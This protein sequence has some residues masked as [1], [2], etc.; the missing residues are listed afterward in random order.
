M[1]QGRVVVVIDVLR[2]STTIATAL[3]QWRQGRH[4][5]RELGRGRSPARRHSSARDVSL[6]GERKMLPIPGFDLGNSPRSSRAEAVEG[7]TIL[8]DDDERH[9]R[10]SRRCRARVTWLSRRTSTSR[11]CCAMLRAALRGGHRHRHGLRGAGAAVRARGCG[12]RRALRRRDVRS[13][14]TAWRLNDAAAASRR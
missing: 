5:A 3:A 4:S 11:R 6:A 12:V 2:A 7:K 9:A 10:A 14:L 1:S 8:H 13:A